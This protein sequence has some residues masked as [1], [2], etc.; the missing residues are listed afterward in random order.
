MTFG[1]L[2]AGAGGFDLGFE[3]AGMECKWQVEINKS[4]ASV[5][6]Y[7]WPNVKKYSDV[8]EVGKHN[9]EP[10]DVIVGGSPCQGFSVAGKREGVTD[11]R[12]SLFAEMVR[13]V[14]E[15]K[16]KF[17]VWENVPGVISGFDEVPAHE[18]YELFSWAERRALAVEAGGLIRQWWLGAVLRSFSDIGY[19]GAYRI[20]DAQ[21]FG[22]PQRRR[23]I[24]AVFSRDSGG[25]IGTG[26]CREIL[27]FENRVPGNTSK[28]KKAGENFTYEFA[29]SLRASGVGSERCGD[30]RCQDCVIPVV[31]NTDRM[32]F[33]PT[34][35]KCLGEIA[36]TLCGEGFDASEDGTGRETPLFAI[37]ERATSENP[38]AGPSGAGFRNDG[39]SYTLEARNT[40]QAVAYRT[41]GNCGALETGDRTDAL[42]TGTDQT[43]H[44]LAFSSKDHGGDAGNISPTLRS[45][46]HDKSHANAGGQVA[47]AQQHSV[48]RLT[49]T[50][51]ER[52]M[53]W[54][55]S[56][57]KYGI[58][59]GQVKVLADGPRYRLCGNGVVSNVAEWI[60]RRIVAVNK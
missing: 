30:T 7:N 33:V 29:P 46:G 60:A 49:P 44:V 42:N 41:S 14:D 48:R 27:A 34:T 36:H 5:L 55:D 54:P 37:Q 57:T 26:R 8:R 51:C 9:L 35:A 3:R 38:N 1:S 39:L 25:H 28:G 21:Y 32:T 12:S 52:L 13:V 47:I 23:R 45:M 53:G 40:P 4:A 17:V 19:V 20:L 18:H 50:E 16:P 24:F 2:F 43:S 59:K 6:E 31:G 10:V 15:I 56:H 22:V 11:H 58:I